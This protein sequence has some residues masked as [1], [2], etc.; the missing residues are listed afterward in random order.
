MI[1]VKRLSLMLS[2][3]VGNNVCQGVVTDIMSRD[4]C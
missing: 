2:L 1:F 4:G 3:G